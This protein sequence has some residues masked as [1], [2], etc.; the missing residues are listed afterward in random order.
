[1]S[2]EAYRAANKGDVPALKTLLTNPATRAAIDQLFKVPDVYGVSILKLLV[3]SC[4]TRGDDWDL[5]GIGDLSGE[6]DIVAFHGAVSF[7]GC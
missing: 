5:D 7:N 3:V 1:M 4:T 6:F 2:V